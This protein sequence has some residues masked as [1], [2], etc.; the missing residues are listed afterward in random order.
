MT[1]TA[2]AFC[3]IGFLLLSYAGERYANRHY[4]QRMRVL[5]SRANRHRLTVSQSHQL[6]PWLC[7][8]CSL[9]P[10]SDPDNRFC[11]GC[12]RYVRALNTSED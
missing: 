3:L 6:T 2:L 12:N 11:D 5:Q 8:N 9:E 1:V 7:D 4:R 10:V